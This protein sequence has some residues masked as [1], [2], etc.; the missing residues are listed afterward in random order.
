MKVLT[1]EGLRHFHDRTKAAADR[2]KIRVD[3]VERLLPCIDETCIM[4]VATSEADKFTLDAEVCSM[5][6]ERLRTLDVLEIDFDEGWCEA[7]VMSVWS[8]DDGDDGIDLIGTDD[9]GDMWTWRISYRNGTAVRKKIAGVGDVAAGGGCQCDSK[10]YAFGVSQ[11][12][13]ANGGFTFDDTAASYLGYVRMNDSLDVQFDDIECFPLVIG[14]YEGNV[15]C[16]ETSADGIFVWW[17]SAN[18]NTGYRADLL[19]ALANSGSGMGSIGGG[20]SVPTTYT[21]TGSNVLDLIK[22]L[23]VGDTVIISSSDVTARYLGCTWEKVTG[24]TVGT[25]VLTGIFLN[26]STNMIFTQELLAQYPTIS[27]G[28]L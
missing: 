25:Q 21:F 6:Q 16:I 8:N 7:L 15:T 9:Q 11:N 4:P 24:Q 20:V 5:L 1:L 22:K 27:A 17:L 19:S 28:G 13:P 26:R 3:N 2:L 18:A 23:C 14:T 10:E 12:A